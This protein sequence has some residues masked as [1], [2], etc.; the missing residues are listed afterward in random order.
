M[1]LTMTTYR[2]SKIICTFWKGK[3]AN[4]KMALGINFSQVYRL[5]M[6][7][8]LYIYRNVCFTQVKIIAEDVKTKK[9]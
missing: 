6:I 1:L 3:R 2:M 4:T 5:C 8:Y 9:N 7:G